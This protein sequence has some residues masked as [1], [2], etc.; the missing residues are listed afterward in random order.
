MER[1][2]MPK[3]LDTVSGQAGSEEGT[4]VG[5][6]FG[7]LFQEREEEDLFAVAASLPASYP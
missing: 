4:I 2:G 1:M 7:Q 6:G 5:S 3:S